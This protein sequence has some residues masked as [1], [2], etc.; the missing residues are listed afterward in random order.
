MSREKIAK[1]LIG[2][3]HLIDVDYDRSYYKYKNRL[4]AGLE[5]LDVCEIS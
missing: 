4:D 2:V 3:A 5:A 1:R